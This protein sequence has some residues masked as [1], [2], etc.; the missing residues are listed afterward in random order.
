[1]KDALGCNLKVIQLGDSYDLWIDFGFVSVHEK[2][3]LIADIE[4]I[5]ADEADSDMIIDFA[6]IK[7][8]IYTSIVNY[9][10]HPIYKQNEN[11]QL[12]ISSI[13]GKN[14][15]TRIVEIDDYKKEVKNS[16][17]YRIDRTKL[18]QKWSE[19]CDNQRGGLSRKNKN[20]KLDIKDCFYDE[21]T[22]ATTFIQDQI[23]RIEGLHPDDTLERFFQYSHPFGVDADFRTHYRNYIKKI[24]KKKDGPYRNAAV[25]AFS[26]LEKSL[27]NNMVYLYG[28][29]DNYLADS[30]L[31]K[32][33]KMRKRDL[34]YESKSLYIEHG[35]RCEFEFKLE[36]P[37]FYDPKLLDKVDQAVAI[38]KDI[39]RGNFFTGKIR[40]GVVASKKG[41]V[42]MNYDGCRSGFDAT[43]DNLK[44]KLSGYFTEKWGKILEVGADGV[45]AVHDQPSYKKTFSRLKIGRT[46]T[47][48]ERI[49]NIFVIGHTHMKCLEVVTVKSYS[50]EKETPRGFFG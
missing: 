50:E 23:K 24:G 30:A 48:H 34:I 21:K 4:K 38:G 13:P 17:L 45:A 44:D 40:L 26:Q 10:K 14:N 22:T 27:G 6:A 29:H 19:W 41:G 43:C 35:H 36:S 25:E 7:K 2:V 9:E 32:E 31:T 15:F 20:A 11:L 18:E 12:E 5:C 37:E 46:L 28:N 33:L 3:N 16:N 1:M 42:P 47:N 39:L 49:P 8:K